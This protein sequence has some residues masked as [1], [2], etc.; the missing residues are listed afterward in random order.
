METR[1]TDSSVQMVPGGECRGCLGLP[2]SG[3][4]RSICKN[5]AAEGKH[6]EHGHVVT[7]TSPWSRRNSRAKSPRTLYAFDLAIPGLAQSCW[8]IWQY[9]FSASAC[10]FQTC[11][12]TVCRHHE[13]MRWGTIRGRPIQ[14]QMSSCDLARVSSC[15]ITRLTGS[16]KRDPC[17]TTSTAAGRAGNERGQC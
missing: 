17:A 1:D 9:R 4:C 10:I 2:T 16:A 15:N 7:V 6:D 11:E 8:A 13:R 5:R 3:G 12:L 14:R